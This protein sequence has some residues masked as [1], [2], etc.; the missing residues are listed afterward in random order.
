MTDFSDEQP[1]ARI[2]DVTY[3]TESIDR[4]MENEIGPNEF[5]SV[6]S[7]VNPNETGARG[8][9]VLG[10]ALLA[11]DYSD[12]ISLNELNDVY[13]HIIDSLSEADRESSFGDPVYAETVTLLKLGLYRENL[14]LESYVTFKHALDAIEAM[15]ETEIGFGIAQEMVFDIESLLNSKDQ[16]IQ[17]ILSMT[18]AK[19]ISFAKKKGKK[20]D[21]PDP[22]KRI[23]FEH[24]YETLYEHITRRS[25]IVEGDS[26]SEQSPKLSPKLVEHL[27]QARKTAE[28]AQCAFYGPNGSFSEGREAT[29]KNLRDA[30]KQMKTP[31]PGGFKEIT[32]AS[33]PVKISMC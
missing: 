20:I 31:K 26:V 33:G 27:N 13:C 19:I 30:I 28:M 6:L 23:E 24:L 15:L 9:I 14:T 17:E 4:F 5:R 21:L 12:M 16:E 11:R 32:L 7:S 1:R 10:Y 29:I 2:T 18:A 3:L 22:D 8:L 25:G